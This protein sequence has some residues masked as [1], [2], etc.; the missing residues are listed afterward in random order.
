[1]KK[2]V[3]SPFLRS[4]ALLLLQLIFLIPA[5]AQTGR[6]IPDWATNVVWYQIFPERFHNADPSND[7]TPDRIGDPHGWDLGAPEGWEISPWTGDWYQRADWEQRVGPQFRD[8]VFTRRYGGDLQGVI[9]KLGYLQ[10]LGVTAIYFNPVFDAVSLHKYDASHYH[11]IDRFLGPDPEGDWEIMQ[12][13]DPADPSTWQWTAADRLFLELVEKARERGIRIVIDGVWNHTGRDFW[14]FRHIREHG[15]DSPYSDWYKISAFGEEY[16][17][18]FD[19]EGW[20]G[21]RG[22]PEFTEVGDNLHPEVKEHIFAVTRR[23][24]APDGDVSRGVAGWRLDVPEEVGNGFWRDW[25]ALVYEINPDALTIAEVW[26]DGARELVADDLFGVVM[27]YRWTYAT[28]AFF[29]HQTLD[30]STFDGRLA[31]LRADFANPTNL[32]MQNLMDSHDTERLATM[33]VNNHKAYK[34]DSKLDRVEKAM[35]YYVHKPNEAQWQLLKLIALFQFTYPG[36]PMVY[37][38]TEAGM[39]GADDP[40]DRKPMVWPEL[41][42]DDEVNHPFGLERPRDPVAFDHELHQWYTMLGQLRADFPETLGTGNFRSLH[43]NDAAHA[44]AFARYDEAGKATIVLINRGEAEY[45]FVI[46]P[47]DLEL[48]AMMNEQV[49]GAQHAVRENTIRMLVPAVS[50]RVL[51]P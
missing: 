51:T 3:F 50:G 7:P 24:M 39:W 19:Y 48:P 21:Y 27:N 28:H 15:Q 16:H 34:E 42:Y 31:E 8:A 22:L 1:M 46:Q 32:A 40:D 41:E 13:E 11:H 14:A 5:F 33:I 17:D 38:G 37:Y 47:G 43:T 20:W 10:A 30:A 49:T 26:G 23:W 9:D 45:E 4:A 2:P 44:F 25:H 12:Q 6:N 29:I 18:G 35:E 36:S